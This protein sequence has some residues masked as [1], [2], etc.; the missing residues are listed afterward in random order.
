M[1]SLRRLALLSGLSA[2]A[3][4]WALPAVASACS[5]FPYVEMQ[6]PADGDTVAVNEL[7]VMNV[8]CGG[9]ASDLEVLVD[10]QPVALLRDET[11]MAGHGYA[12]VPPPPVGAFVEIEGCPGYDSCDQARGLGIDDPSERVALSFTVGEADDL[13][14]M[15]PALLDL[16]HDIDDVWVGN[17]GDDETETGRKWQ[18]TVDG[19]EPQEP[20]L[21]HIEV[22]PVGGEPTTTRRFSAQADEDLELALT[23]LQEDAGSDVCVTVRTFDM[24]GNEAPSV[25]TC[26]T[27]AN[28]DTLDATAGCS[29]SADGDRRGMLGTG[30]LLVL[31]GWLRRRRQ[32]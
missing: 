31:G 7:L 6:S 20:V 18:F 8:S 16:R 23:R 29:C 26:E 5:C 22:G 19:R 15:P 11:R 10:G 14:P 30:L 3:F 17:C 25:S 32:R 9:S 13:T 21:Y 2:A 12:I 1:T 27:L 4:V 28:D 24:A